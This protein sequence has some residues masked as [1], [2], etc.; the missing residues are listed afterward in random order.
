MIKL[1]AIS[2]EDRG[3]IRGRIFDIL[4]ERKEILF[5][6]LHGSFLEDNLNV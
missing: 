1:H 4:K 5:A 2:N 6:Y 3:E